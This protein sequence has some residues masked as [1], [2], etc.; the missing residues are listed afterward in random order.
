MNFA[1]NPTE[2]LSIVI[3]NDFKQV[4]FTDED[5]NFIL[6]NREGFTVQKKLT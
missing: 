4:V 6:E 2:N 1:K 5:E 3:A